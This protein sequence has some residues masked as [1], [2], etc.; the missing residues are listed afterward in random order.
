[1]G[2]GRRPVRV[3]RL[4][5]QVLGGYLTYP[6]VVRRQTTVHAE[7][8]LGCSQSVHKTF[9]RWLPKSHL[10]Y[11]EAADDEARHEAHALYPCESADC[12]EPIVGPQHPHCAPPLPI[13]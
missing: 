11:R 2:W 9:R 13:C 12:T 4:R 10:P 7:K 3:P 1:M 8:A 6:H 5:P